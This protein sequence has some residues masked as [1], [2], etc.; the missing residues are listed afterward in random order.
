MDKPQESRTERVALAVTPS[1]K[2]ALRIL[3]GHRKTTEADLLRSMLMNDIVAEHD[4]LM[5]RLAEVA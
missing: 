2:H 4:R 3:A 5:A 1:E